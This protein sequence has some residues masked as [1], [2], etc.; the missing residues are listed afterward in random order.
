M[1]NMILTPSRG[2]PLAD[3]IADDTPNAET[4][5]AI[6]RLAKRSG[7]T[8]E[9]VHVR[10][11][12][13]VHDFVDTYFSRFEPADVK[14]SAA[15]YG[16]GNGVPV[17]VG[18]ET[19]GAKPQARIFRGFAERRDVKVPM[20]VEGVGEGWW[21]RADFYWMR[22]HSNASDLALEID[23][24]I[25]S[26]VSQAWRFKTPVCSICETDLR[27]CAHI[28]GNVYNEK[29]CWYAMRGVESVREVS[30]VYRGGQQ[31]TSLDLSRAQASAAKSPSDLVDDYLSAIGVRVAEED[32]A[33]LIEFARCYGGPEKFTRKDKAERGW[34]E[35]LRAKRTETNNGG[36]AFWSRR[37]RTAS[38]GR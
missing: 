8:A 10:S 26:E 33:G 1:S 9:D 15:L 17:M 36:G 3:L 32:R 29:T 6:R 31:G 35:S 24:G 5:A 12:F 23:G 7:I 11:A 18:H 37:E 27:D 20:V 13:V 38:P 30:F 14:R 25:L 28:P 34:F 16:E 19:Y 2:A 22:A 21:A 4:M